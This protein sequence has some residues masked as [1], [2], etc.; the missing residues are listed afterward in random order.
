MTETATTLAR[1]IEVMEAGLYSDIV[2]NADCDFETYSGFVVGVGADYVALKEV[3]DMRL[4]GTRIF[5]IAIIEDCVF[6]SE[7]KR[8][9][10]AILASIGIEQPTCPG[11]L[12]LD[13]PKSCLA[14]IASNQNWMA[15]HDGQGCDIGQV[16]SVAQ[17]KF[18]LK[19]VRA[20]GEWFD[21]I[22]EIS[23][24]DVTHLNIGGHYGEV[25]RRYMERETL[26]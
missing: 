4:E 11:W 14:S 20:S 19:A 10:Q 24:D 18:R 17:D 21:E 25:Y 1:L 13:D 2:L 8:G 16:V 12:S 15:V 3:Y 26:T 22:F 7:T 23:Y 5:S 6:G 9:Q